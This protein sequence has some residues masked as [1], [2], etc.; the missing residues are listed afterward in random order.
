MGRGGKPIHGDGNGQRSQVDSSVVLT[1]VIGSVIYNDTPDYGVFTMDLDEGVSAKA[2]EEAS[3]QDL[4]TSDRSVKV[5][6]RHCGVLSRGQRVKIQG[7]WERSRFGWQVNA[8]YLVSET[9]PMTLVAAGFLRSRVDGVG[10]QRAQFMIDTF[11]DELP[12]VVDDEEVLQKV[13]GIG[14]TLAGRIVKAWKTLTPKDLALLELAGYGVTPAA[15]KAL[16]DRFGL[17][18]TEVIQGNPWEACKVRGLGFAA[19][20]QLAIRFEVPFT[21][22]GRAQA[23]ILECVKQAVNQEGSIRVAEGRV[24]SFADGL[25]VKRGAAEQALKD[26]LGDGYLVRPEQ[27]LL[28]LTAHDAMEKAVAKKLLELAKDPR[29]GTPMIPEMGGAQLTDAQRK[30]VLGLQ[31]FGAGLLVGGP[32][33]GKTFTCRAIVE[34]FKKRWPCLPVLLCAPTGRASKQLAKATGRTAMTV[35]RLLEW[36]GGDKWGFNRNNKLPQALILVDEVSMVDIPLAFRLL[37]AVSEGSTV[38]FVGDKD[39]LPSVGPGAVLRDVLRS[40]AIPVYRLQQIIRQVAGNPVIA[41]THR[42]NAGSVPRSGKT[43]QGEVRVINRRAQGAKAAVATAEDV[44]AGILAYTRW[45]RDAKGLT[46]KDVQVLCLGHRSACGVK[47]MNEALLKLWLPGAPAIRFPRGARVINLKNDYKIG[48]MNG[49]MGVVV[50]A[51]IGHNRKQ[52]AALIRW[53]G[54]SEPVWHGKPR[55]KP[56]IKGSMSTVQLSYATTVHK[57]Q[58]SEVQWALVSVHLGMG[59]PLHTREVLYTAASRAKQGLVIVAPEKALALC[60]KR[61]QGN[62]RKTGLESYLRDGG[63][64]EKVDSGVVAGSRSLWCG[65]VVH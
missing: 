11:G 60:C 22:P 8:A 57:A 12:D 21:H 50:D 3:I 19:A 54:V 15:C 5:Q 20:D 61:A 36:R 13:P 65:G 23:A 64:S 10:P 14:P 16:V 17:R 35:H 62:M 47:A 41:Q 2:P 30:A 29:A 46:A 38:L 51:E 39:Q 27:G 24:L 37:S 32:G 53:D 9:K 45:L 58:G 43:E 63:K 52:S 4:W 42:I 59:Y 33:V 1:G 34:S 31:R 6:A 7:V 40:G 25:D 55:S 49:D 56:P 48:V 44:S 26:M 18:A 28:A